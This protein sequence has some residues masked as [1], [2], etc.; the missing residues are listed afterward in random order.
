MAERMERDPLRPHLVA[1]LAAL[2]EIH[3]ANRYGPECD[4]CP[5]AE[6]IAAARRALA[7]TGEDR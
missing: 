7:S 2:V 1:T 3:D 5:T 4:T 6:T